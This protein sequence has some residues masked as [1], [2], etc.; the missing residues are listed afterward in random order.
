MPRR[1]PTPPCPCCPPRHNGCCFALYDFS[2]AGT[3]PRRHPCPP[4]PRHTQPAFSRVRCKSD[5]LETSAKPQAAGVAHGQSR[6]AAATRPTLAANYHLFFFFWLALSP[7]LHDLPLPIEAFA[8]RCA[9]E[10]IPEPC[11]TRAPTSIPDT[12]ARAVAF[13]LSYCNFDFS[14]ST[15]V[16][17]VPLVG[18]L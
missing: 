9:A 3:R 10:N 2:C 14:L 4:G 11:V 5:R 15:K 8:R 6:P 17:M 18:Y 1:T 13:W 16:H 7:A 12:A